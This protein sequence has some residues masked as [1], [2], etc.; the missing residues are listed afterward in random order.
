MSTPVK[1]GA[2]NDIFALKNAR[3]LVGQAADDTERSLGEVMRMRE[4]IGRPDYNRIN[5]LLGKMAGTLAKASRELDEMYVI[6]A[7]AGV[8]PETD[9]E[10]E[11]AR[12]KERQAALEAELAEIK[13]KLQE[14]N[15]ER[16][17]QAVST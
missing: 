5:H 13:V 14:G 3:R 15:H 17:L 1:V 9:L 11:V 4:A 6:R 12:L 2:R 16:P 8:L 7:N 10:E